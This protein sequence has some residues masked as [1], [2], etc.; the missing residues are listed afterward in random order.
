ML[1]KIIS[2]V[3]TV[4]GTKRYKQ[5]LLFS[6]LAIAIS[7]IGI[8]TFVSLY[9]QADYS[10]ASTVEQQEDVATNQSSGL[11]KQDLKKQTPAVQPV[12]PNSASGGA[13]PTSPE[14]QTPSTPQP[15]ATPDII[16][17]ETPVI[18]LKKGATSTPL[19]IATA[20]GSKVTWSATFENTTGL[21]LE[22]A[23]DP[24][25]AATA[26]FALKA[27]SSLTSGQYTVIIQAK[28]AGRGVALKPLSITITVP[29]E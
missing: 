12:T 2:F 14:T 9:D 25:A 24:A 29:A 4:F 3:I 26:T 23:F 7:L 27:D 5:P 22:S 20:D 8:T 28:D 10:A 21:T 18:T 16:L 15:T 1:V 11:S 13:T 17:K 19:H 6:G